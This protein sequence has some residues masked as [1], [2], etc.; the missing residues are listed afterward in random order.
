MW[1]T[2][3][4]LCLVLSGKSARKAPHRRRPAFRRPLM[5][6]LED[7]TLPS[8]YVVTTAADSG[9]GSLRDAINVINNDTAGN[10]YLGSHGVDEIDF[11]LPWNDSG[12]V[13]YQGSVGNTQP[14]PGGTASDADLGGTAAPQWQH[15][16]WRIQVQ[17]ALPTITGTVFIDG[18]SQSGAKQN[19]Q[20]NDDDA[21]LRVELNG[22]GPTPVNGNGLSIDAPDTTVRGLV[23]NGFLNNSAIDL[24]GMSNDRVQGNFIGTDVSGT[25][26]PYGLPNLG[27]FSVS[28]NDLHIGVEVH[29]STGFQRDFI[30]AN[31]GD[32]LTGFGERNLLSAAGAGV[33][34]Y[35]P[36][37][38]DPTQYP[39]PQTNNV[40][41]G[42]FIGTDTHGTT[43]LGNWL[44]LAWLLGAH[45]DLIGTNADGVNDAGERNVISGNTWGVLP[46]GGTALASYRGTIA[47]N[48]I[49][50]D[51]NGSPLG[52]LWAGVAE[53]VG[54]QSDRIGGPLPNEGN[55]IAY[56]GTNSPS[57]YHDFASNG[58]LYGNAP[59]VWI[60]TFR[61]TPVNITVQGN[62]I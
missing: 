40:V 8:A 14:V 25:L 37:L 51:V 54:S 44:G 1:P 28:T 23:I 9:P 38:T 3:L 61:S 57:L 50:T 60:A 59:G 32:A 56:N 26:A 33:A 52:N 19:D 11:A 20:P 39:A 13:Y 48:F 22:R 21:V 30:G 36:G 31:S 46:G 15:S 58:I 6:A 42:N 4:T 41:A 43:A 49:G 7:R 29:E 55:T 5:E 45:D 17:S 34:F 53:S 18:Y 24:Q 47:G 10:Q 16:W 2:F 27:T 12:H 35:G 62:S